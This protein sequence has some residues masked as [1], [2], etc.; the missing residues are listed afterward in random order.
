VPAQDSYENPRSTGFVLRFGEFRFLDLGD[1]TGK[2]LF[3][4][5]CPADLVGPVDVYLLAH[6]GGADAAEP[7]TLAAFRPRLTVL[8]NGARKGGAAATF[9]MLQSIPDVDVWQLHRSQNPEVEN[10]RD[11]QIANLDE[12][13]GYWIKLNANAD[14]S[15]RVTNG[16][17][18]VT[19]SYSKR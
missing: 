9:K 6:H 14:G 8:N 13:T 18:G 1:L 3:D 16:R 15:F 7:A 10:F 5:V 12:S 17:T 2:P 19:K 11:E 4:L